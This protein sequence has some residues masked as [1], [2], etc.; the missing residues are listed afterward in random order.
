MGTGAYAEVSYF[1]KED[2]ANSEIEPVY[3]K[4]KFVLEAIIEYLLKTGDLTVYLLLTD[5]AKKTNYIG[6]HTD[7]NNGCIVQG[8]KERQLSL[9]TKF[10]E[11]LKFEIIE[12]VEQGISSDEI[13]N[14]F[15]IITKHIKKNDSIYVD[16]T[17]AFRSLPFLMTAILNYASFCHK[18]LTVEE[19]FYGVFERGVETAPILKL[20]EYVRLQKWTNAVDK[21]LTSG[22][23]D[24]SN[25][26]KEEIQ[27][28]QK[29]NSGEFPVEL[30]I[31]LEVSLRNYIETLKTNRVRENISE[32]LKL[33]EHFTQLHEIIETDSVDFKGLKPFI[34]VLQRL[35]KMVENYVENDVINNVYIMTKQCYAFGMYQQVFTLTQ[36]NIINCLMINRCESENDYYDYSLREEIRKKYLK[37][38]NNNISCKIE[39]DNDV[40]EMIPISLLSDNGYEFYRNQK[41]N[42]V[43]HAGMNVNPMKAND[44]IVE[45]QRSINKFEGLF[46][47]YIN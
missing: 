30:L 38:K 7:R 13:W 47:K 24:I 5:E 14:I 43:S 4:T 17:H 23:N 33:K 19:I 40:A 20:S 12:N 41:R 6:G 35:E 37:I 11:R 25:L 46:L 32:A 1:V 2:E 16:I 21:C 34:Y 39:S 42:D 3:L 27:I 10:G 22:Q 29:K 28:L 9:E 18:M 26:L 31:K 45:A 44:V 8:F 15:Y 36:E